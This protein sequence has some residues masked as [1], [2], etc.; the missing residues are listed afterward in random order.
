MIDL[1]QRIL[2]NLPT[3][4]LAII[5]AVIAWLTAITAA[6]P[7]ELHVYSQ[8]VPVHII[9]QDTD[10]IINGD[11]NLQVQVTINAPKSV[12]Q[13]LNSK[14][15][16][17]HASVDLSGLGEGIHTL[18]V[19]VRVDVRPHQVKTIT[20]ASVP[21]NLEQL[22]SDSKQVQ[23]VLRGEPAIGYQV[24]KATVNPSTASITGPKSLVNQVTG[25]RIT[26][27]L[28][29]ARE[30]ISSTL[31]ITPVDIYGDPVENVTVS[32]ARAAIIL[33]VT[34]KGG[35]RN[36]VVKVVSQG[37]LASGYRLTNI[38]VYPPNIT[39]F[40]EDP[41]LVEQLPG[42]IETK[43][44]LL[45]N[46]KSDTTSPVDLNLPA[47]ISLV[48]NQVVTVT[49]SVEPVETSLTISRVPVVI[50][51]LASNLNVEISPDIVDILISGPL[52]VLD[53]LKS[54]EIKITID[55]TGKG[56]G[57]Y[58]ITP[59]VLIDDPDVRIESV[60]PGTIEVKITRK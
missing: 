53:V 16:L 42:Y 8:P 34:Q 27:D 3:L 22:V 29:Q 60:I 26:V 44:I 32:P 47:G 19:H 11:S 35:Y 17:I 21:I 15:S 38:S 7:N 52:P 30:N 56:P 49:T 33:P 59:P 24:E 48:G 5:L 58:Q 54:Q 9:G 23:L 36:V 46:L 45:D 39:V 51:G 1:L 10:L 57:T 31:D 4:L 41:L 55:L 6:D 25:L 13:Q 43:P 2:K 18:P 50:T 14:P 12:W 20:P 37:K 28:T 40:S